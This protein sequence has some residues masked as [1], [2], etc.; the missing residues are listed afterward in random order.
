MSELEKSRRIEGGLPEMTSNA[1][2]EIIADDATVAVSGFGSVGYPKAVPLALADAGRDFSLTI[3]SGGS[4]GGE[5]DRT[6]VEADAISR[7]YPYQA[8]AV[9][10]EAVNSGTIAFHDRHISGLADEVTSG[11]LSSLDVAIVEA[12]A[13]GTDWFIPTTSIGHTPAYV[14]Q[15]SELIVEVNLA[16]PSEL[17]ELHDVYRPS[18][19]QNREPIPITD[20]CDRIGD[21][22]IE[23]DPSK[24]V[25]V[26]TT[27]QRDSPYTFRSPTDEDRQIAANLRELLTTEMEQNPVFE[28]SLCLQFGVGS[29][30]NALMSEL[31]EMPMDDRSIAYFG[32]VIQ[33]GLLDMLADGRL[34]VASATSLALSEEGQTRLFENFDSFVDDLILRPADVSNAPELINRL[35]M[36]SVNSALEVDIYGHVNSTHIEGSYLVNGIGGSNDYTRNAI[37]SVIALPSTADDGKVSR[38]CPMVPHVDHTEHDVSAI[39]TE[40]GVAD[41]R[42]LSPRERAL[43]IIEY[44]AH[45]KYQAQLRKY[46]E[47]SVESGGHVPHDL[48]SAFDWQE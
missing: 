24:L 15:A 46:Y 19:P 41:L 13:V 22:K 17:A 27:D 30:G 3:I 8:N 26:V 23:F 36:I 9:S 1:A 45:P 48:T 5:I 25:A 34:E 18:L 42:G 14:E 6:L 44:C 40:Q 38:I 47:R 10:R 43:E 11:H 39:I 28:E 12:V 21:R 20:P 33:D 31:S 4:V 35:G 16:Q 7:R 2:V 37:V 29:L 32:E